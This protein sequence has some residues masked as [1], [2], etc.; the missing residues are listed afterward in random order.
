M[1]TALRRGVKED[2]LSCSTLECTAIDTVLYLRY[3]CGPRGLIYL[4]LIFLADVSGFLLIER[5]VC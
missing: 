5:K 3:D 2:T 1:A 4:F